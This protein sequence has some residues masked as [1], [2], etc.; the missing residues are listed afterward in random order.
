MG[1]CEI[2][3]LNIPQ[4]RIVDHSEAEDSY[5][6]VKYEEVYPKAY[7]TASQARASIGR[8]LDFYNRCQP[9]SEP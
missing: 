5:R 1:S 7:D 6:G 2:V 4:A 3:F 9:H 8:Y